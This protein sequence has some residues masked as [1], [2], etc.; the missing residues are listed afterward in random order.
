LKWWLGAGS[1]W[2]SQVLFKHTWAT[3][4]TAN[5]ISSSQVN[6]ADNT[7]NY[8]NITG[9]QLEADT[10]ASDFEFL[11]YDVNLDRCQ[12]YYFNKIGGTNTNDVF[13]T[14]F[15]ST[16]TFF[17]AGKLN[18]TMRSSPSASVSGTNSHINYTI[19]GVGASANATPSFTTN[20]DSFLLV[21]LLE[22]EQQIMQVPILE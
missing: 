8:I 11:P 13:A 15:T 19:V 2:N 4:V 3:P 22:Q 12:R 20:L 10:S 5:R 21:L 17:G 1:Q 16:N 14:G 9:V 7:S 6:L 18:K